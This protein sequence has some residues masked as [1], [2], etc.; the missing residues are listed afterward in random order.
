MLTSLNM[1][2]CCRLRLAPYLTAEGPEVGAGESAAERRGQRHVA[3]RRGEVGVA[4]GG[5]RRGVRRLHSVRIT[6]SWLH[7]FE[8]I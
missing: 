3:E 4:A 7:I 6:H 2:R 8:T 1:R 5:A